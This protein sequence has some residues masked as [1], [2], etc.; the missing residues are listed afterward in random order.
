MPRLSLSVCGNNKIQIGYGGSKSGKSSFFTFHSFLLAK[1]LCCSYFLS[2]S[3]TRTTFA[4]PL[5]HRASCDAVQHAVMVMVVVAAPIVAYVL[6]FS[7][8]LLLQSSVYIHTRPMKQSKCFAELICP[9]ARVCGIGKHSIPG[10]VF[11][12]R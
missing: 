4:T 9:D 2:L 7:L 5:T 11:H 12:E 1:R 6:S 10:L 8:S 3:L